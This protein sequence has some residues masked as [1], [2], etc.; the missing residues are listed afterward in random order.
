MIEIEFVDVKISFPGNKSD[1]LDARLEKEF[2][3]Q[4]LGDWMKGLSSLMLQVKGV[5]KEGEYAD[6]I[7]GSNLGK[8][9]VVVLL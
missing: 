3:P 9:A 8:D 7:L 2:F 1:P 5:N 6:M 4:G